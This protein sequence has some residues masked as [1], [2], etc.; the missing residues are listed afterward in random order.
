MKANDPCRARKRTLRRWLF[1]PAALLVMTSTIASAG[2]VGAVATTTA[3]VTGSTPVPVAP[4]PSTPPAQPAPRVPQGAGTS[5][6]ISADSPKVSQLTQDDTATSDVWRDANGATQVQL[7]AVPQNYQPAGST[8]F[9]PIITTLQADPTAAGRWQSTANTWTASFGSSGAGTDPVQVTGTAA[10]LGFAAVG[11]SSVTPSVS[12]S[13]ATYAGLWPDVNANYVVTTTGVTENLVLTAA[14]AQSTFDFDLNPTVTAQPGTATGG[15]ALVSG[16]QTVATV[17][18]LIVE[19]AQGTTVPAGTSGATLTAAANGTGRNGG[20][21]AI[22][23]SP[24]WLAGLPSDDFP[25]TIDPSVTLFD[26]ASSG[27][28][29]STS[30]AINHSEVETGCCRP[31]C[32]HMHRRHSV[33]TARPRS[34]MTGP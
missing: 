10:P 3:P 18:P 21:V 15:L 6:K 12:G 11:A 33:I 29:V 34:M 27:Y 26:D 25:V 9:V 5:Q 13:T 7:F 17:P 30:N 28:T 16:E 19:T 24:T 32:L 23:V 2:A 1:G 8:T 14:G 20:R 22:S 4:L 31:R